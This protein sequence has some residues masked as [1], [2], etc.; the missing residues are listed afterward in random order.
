M[1][2]VLACHN[3]LE[4]TH[5]KDRHHWSSGNG[6]RYHSA[7]VWSSHNTASQQHWW[8]VT[9]VLD[10]TTVTWPKDLD[11]ELEQR[12]SHKRDRRN[13]WTS[14]AVDSFSWSIWSSIRFQRTIPSQVSGNSHNHLVYS[15]RCKMFQWGPKVRLPWRQ[16]RG[17][18]GR[19]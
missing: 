10:N 7:P 4:N 16:D 11:M 9:T 6:R 18:L 15:S 19:N 3:G 12:W 5:R 8:P 13:F 2:L 17:N 14:E 1:K